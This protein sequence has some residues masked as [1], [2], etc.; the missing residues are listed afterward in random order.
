[1]R[2]PVFV[3]LAVLCALPL[4]PRRALAEAGPAARLYLGAASASKENG[5]GQGGLLGYQS[6]TVR[7][8]HAASYWGAELLGVKVGDGAFPILTGDAGLRYVFLPDSFLRP[9]LRVNLGLSLV[10]I[11]PV[12]SVGGA[13][14]LDIPIGSELHADVTFGVRRVLNLFSLKDSLTLGVVEL[15][16]G[17]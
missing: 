15:G 2:R 1:M 14:G 16:V 8:P 4:V 12:P 10:I 9:Y 6:F 17:F 7:G 5:S 11:L 3:L 13:V